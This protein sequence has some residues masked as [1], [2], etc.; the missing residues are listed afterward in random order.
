[1]WLLLIM[2]CIALFAAMISIVAYFIAPIDFEQYSRTIGV[3][4]KMIRRRFRTLDDLGHSLKFG[5]NAEALEMLLKR[6]NRN[7]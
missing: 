5:E 7:D 3:K 4:K 2:L 6:L 1:M